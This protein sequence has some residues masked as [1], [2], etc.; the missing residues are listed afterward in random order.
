MTLEPFDAHFPDVHPRAFVHPNATLI[1]DVR[2][3]G[4]RSLWPGAVLRA[5]HAPIRVGRKTSIQEIVVVHVA[6]GGGT[7]IGSSCIIGHLAFLEE[8]LVEAGA[9]SASAR[10]S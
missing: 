3:G 2:I 8:A 1:G 9:W 4:H 10:G 7:M 5:D 6:P